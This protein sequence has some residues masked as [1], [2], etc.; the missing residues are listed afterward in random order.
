MRASYALPGGVG[1]ASLAFHDGAVVPSFAGNLFVAARA[2]YLLRVR[3]DESDAAKA[4]TSEKLLEGKVGE[5][6]AVA[7]APDGAIYVATPQS[8]WRLKVAR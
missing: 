6:R 1:V 2:G 3:F 4:M 5:L 7:V 8:V